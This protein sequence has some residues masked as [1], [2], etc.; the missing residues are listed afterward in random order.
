MAYDLAG[1]AFA[2]RV[3]IV[4]ADDDLVVAHRVDEQAQGRGVEHHAVDE[5]AVGVLARRMGRVAAHELAPAMP[6]VVETAEPV[7]KAAPTVSEADP[8]RRGHPIEH[9]AEDH[10]QHREMRLG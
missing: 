6:G 3:G 2:E 9:P 8:Q 7:R 1:G 5:E 4:A 10:R